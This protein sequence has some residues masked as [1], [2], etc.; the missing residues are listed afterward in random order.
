MIREERI[1]EHLEECVTRFL[2]TVDQM[3]VEHI[4]RRLREPTSYVNQQVGSDLTKWI[5]KEA[6]SAAD[7]HIRLFGGCS[8]LREIVGGLWDAGKEKYIKNEVDRRLRDIVKKIGLEV[9]PG[10]G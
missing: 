10:G 1:K 7:H 4:N 5:E 8:A 6:K 3:L 2:P 9:K